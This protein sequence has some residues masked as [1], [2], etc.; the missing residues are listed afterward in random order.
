MSRKDK[1]L[2]ETAPVWPLAPDIPLAPAFG[3]DK[4]AAADR[5]F[6]RN[7]FSRL[8]RARSPDELPTRD[9][10]GEPVPPEVVVVGRSNAGKSTLLN[11][12][13]AQKGLAPASKQP[14]RTQTFDMYGIAGNALSRF[15]NKG[16][17]LDHKRR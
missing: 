5:L 9:R 14:G 1:R 11:A 3:A 7:T 15:T 2:L 17:N 4:L 10:D 8:L 12:M 13:W 6:R 16:K